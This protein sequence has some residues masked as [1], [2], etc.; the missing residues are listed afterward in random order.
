MARAAPSRYSPLSPRPRF[1]SDRSIIVSAFVDFLIALL[2]ILVVDLSLPLRPGPGKRWETIVRTLNYCGVS[3]CHRKSRAIS[4]TFPFILRPT[5]REV[6]PRSIRGKDLLV[7]GCLALPRKYVVFLKAFFERG[8]AGK[9]R[10]VYIVQVNGKLEIQ[11]SYVT[12]IRGMYNV[13]FRNT[14]TTFAR[15]QFSL[16]YKIIVWSQRFARW[17]NS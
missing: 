7:C 1:V 4:N 12:F 9:P 5:F 8:L 15:N 10:S 2:K 14:S 13:Y 17:N 11:L 3:G 6:C 16:K